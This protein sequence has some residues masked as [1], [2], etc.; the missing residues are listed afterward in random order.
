[1]NSNDSLIGK[2]LDEY[3]LE[4]LLGK[5][6]MAAVYLSVDTRLKRHVAIKV[7]TSPFR[8]DSGYIERF[9]REAQAIAQLDH[10]GIITLYRYGQVDN[11]LYMAMQYIDGADLEAVIESYH[12]DGD[13]VEPHDILRLDWRC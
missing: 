10:P 9:E 1:M 13:F 6:G 11:L 3:R 5:G 2:Q 4:K 8:A 12:A 7:I